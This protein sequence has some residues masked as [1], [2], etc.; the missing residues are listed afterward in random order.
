MGLDKT[1]LVAEV[2]RLSGLSG[3]AGPDDGQLFDAVTAFVDAFDFWYIRVMRDAVPDY[4]NL[5]IKRINPFV[6]RIECDGLDTNDTAHR[7][8]QDYNARNFVTAGGWAIEALASSGRPEVHKSGI[9]GID[10]DRFDPSTGEFH[11]YVLKS[12]IVTR[13]SDILSALKRNARQAERQLRQDRRTKGVRANY[14]IAAGK[15]TSTFD[16][17]VWRP[18]S[19]EFWGE[20]FDLPED[21]AV[22]LALAIATVAGRLVRRDASNHVAALTTAVASYIASRTN[23]AEVDWDFLAERC[24]RKKETWVKEDAARHKQALADLAG[25]GYTV[26]KKKR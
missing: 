13:N 23:S 8:V 22:D 16:D 20:M 1:A 15:T 26:T 19:A 12:G 10:L 5:I 9:A 7:L 18:S 25:T 4:R 14:A 21:D 3:P 24:M 17:G 2:R 11:L 6:R